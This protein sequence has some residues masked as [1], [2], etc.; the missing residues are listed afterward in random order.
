M[1]R[2]L[3]S[4]KAEVEG[5]EREVEQIQVMERKIHRSG[6]KGESIKGELLSGERS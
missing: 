2:E 6:G 4:K 5:R 1:D 3:N